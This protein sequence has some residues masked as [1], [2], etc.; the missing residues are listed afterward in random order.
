[1][2]VTAAEPTAATSTPP[3]AI[4]LA[5]FSRGSSGS[6]IARARVSIEL[7]REFGDQDQAST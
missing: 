3:A 5:V 1:M 6:P 4:S 2:I 7:C